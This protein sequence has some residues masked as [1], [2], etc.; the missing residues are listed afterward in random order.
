MSRRDAA[1]AGDTVS[2]PHTWRPFGVRF[3]A[4]LFGGMLV[5][6]SVFV[7]I[8]LGADV[9]ARFTPFQRITLVLIGLAGLAI[10]HA[11]ARSRVTARADALV[12]VNGYRSRSFEWAEVISVQLRRGAPFATLDLADGSTLSLWGLQGSD[13][14]RAVTGVRQLHDVIGAQGP[15]EPLG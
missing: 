14:A 3:A 5:A 7:W 11:L 8:A 4:Y 12:V 6:L 15:E 9:R 2:L 1:G 13:G 10:L